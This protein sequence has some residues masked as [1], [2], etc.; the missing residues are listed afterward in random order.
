MLTLVPDR[1]RYTDARLLAD[2]D[3]LT[4]AA[5]LL[6][7][8]VVLVLLAAALIGVGQTWAWSLTGVALGLALSR[9]GPPWWPGR[10]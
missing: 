10:G 4:R 7:E 9:H 1:D 3:D 6:L 2:V 5:V 8:L